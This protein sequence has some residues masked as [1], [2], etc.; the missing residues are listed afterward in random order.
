MC[1]CSILLT[2]GVLAQTDTSPVVNPSVTGV[3][4]HVNRAGYSLKPIGLAVDEWPKLRLDFS[5]E[6]EDRTTF[7]NLTLPDVE[8]KHDGIPYTS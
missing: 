3:A 4:S 2:R 5:I 8:S 6:R 7:R 1:L